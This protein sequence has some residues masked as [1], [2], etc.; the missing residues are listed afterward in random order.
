MVSV[1]SPSPQ[2][3]LT[4][5]QIVEKDIPEGQ[6][7]LLVDRDELPEGGL[8]FH[9]AWRAD[10]TAQVLT[11]DIVVARQIAQ[12]TVRSMRDPRFQSLDIEYQRALEDDDR[13]RM[14]QVIEKKQFL[15]DLPNDNRIERST[16]TGEL[17]RA[18]EDIEVSLKKTVGE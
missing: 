10:Y 7:H 5:E 9:E 14:S 17:C 12:D 13:S 6:P 16:T 8:T 11:V 2:C 3:G 15:R 1:L 18:I 4:L